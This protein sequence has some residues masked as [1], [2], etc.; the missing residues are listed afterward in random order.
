MKQILIRKIFL[1]IFIAI[2]I[3]GC[4]PYKGSFFEVGEGTLIGDQLLIGDIYHLNSGRVI[5]GNIFGIGTT[6]IIESG[7]TIKGN[8]NAIACTLEIS[9]LVEGDINVIAGSSR[10]LSEAHIKGN[11]NQ[12][13]QQAIISPQS[14]IDGEINTF[15]IPIP[16]STP[17]SK[18]VNFATEWVKP[19]NWIILQL[20]RT[21]TYSLISMLAIIIGKRVFIHFADS[22]Q[23]NIAISWGTGFLAI[24]AIPIA[25]LLL[26]ITI[27]LS[28]I[29]L[30]LLLTF[31]LAILFG[32]IALAAVFGKMLCA[33][34]NINLRAELQIFC[35]AFLLGTITSV[36]GWIP[37]IG[38]LI[39][40][41][42][43]T[44]GLGGVILSAIDYYRLR[45]EITEK[46]LNNS[47]S[48]S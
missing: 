18:I 12:L 42:I 29:G 48:V 25:V 3:T 15:T 24:I 40:T 21:I 14:Q 47:S 33:W 2:F 17:I 34:L 32:W 7:S 23:T 37:C 45:R 31:A 36:L 19:V 20:L 28:P 13:Y 1:L 26:I 5:D 39:S 44:I 6:L 30:L 27:C 43:G 38:W 10:I 11:I 22:I 4:I 9:G 8:I 41:T 35:G 16:L 46:K